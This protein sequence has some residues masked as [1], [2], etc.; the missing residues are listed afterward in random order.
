MP[1]NQIWCVRWAKAHP[2]PHL[3]GWAL[4]HRYGDYVKRLNHEEHE[5]HEERKTHRAFPSCFFLLLLRVL[6]VLRGSISRLKS[7]PP[8]PLHSIRPVEHTLHP[9]LI[10]EIPVDGMRDSGFERLGL[11]PPQ[12]ALDLRCVDRVAAI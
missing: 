6:R 7:S 8:Q 9:G 12:I 10:R 3:V 11:S 1:W 5:E 2:T 4:A